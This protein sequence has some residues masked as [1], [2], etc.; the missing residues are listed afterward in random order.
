MGEIPKMEK[1]VIVRQK[2]QEIVRVYNC[3]YCLSPTWFNRV[4]ELVTHLHKEHLTITL[5]AIAK[6]NFI[7]AKKTNMRWC[8]SV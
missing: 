5:Y 1:Q 2:T 3:P 7:E 4:Q 8:I 6:A